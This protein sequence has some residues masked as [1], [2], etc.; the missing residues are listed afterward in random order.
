MFGLVAWHAASAAIY[1]IR[2]TA[3]ICENGLWRFKIRNC[4]H[5]GHGRPCQEPLEASVRGER[6]EHLLRSSW[7]SSL[8]GEQQVKGYQHA[9]PASECSCPLARAS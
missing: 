7:Q 6:F 1:S 4:S 5:A 2:T 9:A 8:L 3:A